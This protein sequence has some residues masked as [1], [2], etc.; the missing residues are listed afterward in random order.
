MPA[1]PTAAPRLPCPTPSCAAPHVVRNGTING[2]QRYRGPSML[3]RE[4]GV[5]T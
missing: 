4:D 1:H 3:R 5:H 2:R